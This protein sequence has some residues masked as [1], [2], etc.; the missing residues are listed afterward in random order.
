MTFYYYLSKLMSEF[1]SQKIVSSYYI[2]YLLFI[3][4][5]LHF[6]SAH[7]RLPIPIFYLPPESRYI[8]EG[9]RRVD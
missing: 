2:F 5:L 6:I 7:L 3:F 1:R 4:T 9:S 8:Y